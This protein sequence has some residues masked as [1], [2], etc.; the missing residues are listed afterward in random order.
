MLLIIHFSCKSVIRDL[1]HR[2]QT[3][4]PLSGVVS[5][6]SL[7]FCSL[8]RAKDT[9]WGL[10]RR[11]IK[12]SFY[13]TFFM[14]LSYIYIFVCIHIY[15][16]LFVCMHAHLYTYMSVCVRRLPNC[17]NLY[18]YTLAMVACTQDLMFAIHHTPYPFRVWDGW[19]LRCVA[20]HTSHQLSMLPYSGFVS[21][22]A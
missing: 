11:V 13:T 14:F 6:H 7:R 17:I 8:G 1:C 15:V 5:H 18:G 20:H 16:S 12:N 4:G 9:F 19:V 10:A 21:L 3:L 2:F 22:E